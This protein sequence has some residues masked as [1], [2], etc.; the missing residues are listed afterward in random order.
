MIY[1][2]IIADISALSGIEEIWATQQALISA[3][4]L[5]HWI[6][7]RV[8]IIIDFKLFKDN[9]LYLIVLESICLHQY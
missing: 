7:Q 6:R 1:R 8:R 9:V 4:W 3:N 2:I 5:P